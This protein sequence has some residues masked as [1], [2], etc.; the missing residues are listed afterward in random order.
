MTTPNRA[1]FDIAPGET[2]LNG[3]A[4]APMPRAGRRAVDEAYV[5]KASPHRVTV[6]LMFS[7]HDRVRERLG[8][9]LGLAASEWGVTTSTTFGITLLAQGIRW[10]AGDRLLLGPDEFPS[11]VYPWLPLEERGVTLDFIGRKGHPLAPDDLDRALDA[12]GRVRALTV[13]AVHYLTG[14]LHP[15]PAFAER[16]HARGALL[17]VDASQAA[18]AIALDWS[19]TGA[20]AIVTSGYKWLFGPYGCGAIWVRP[21]VRETLVDANGNW[22]AFQYGADL[23]RIMDS[24]PP[25]SRTPLPHGRRFDA[26]EAASFLNVA[27]FGAGLEYLTSIGVAA[28]EAHHRALQD[29]IVAALDGLPLAPRTDLAAPHR[30]PMVMVEARGG[31]DLERLC[32]DLAARHVH[33]S[34][35]SGRMRVSPGAWNDESDVAVF[36]EAV[37]QSVGAIGK[38][39]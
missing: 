39:R 28:V 17:V 35:R 8:T 21:A 38:T 20:D 37:A 5:L 7:Y 11:N 26:G 3:A 10:R 36:A 16:L 4:M 34:L 33:V 1:D 29:R 24:Y 2:Y 22:T 14:N 32:A 23:S 25:P 27:A 15:L 31:I 19:A 18:G 12:D 9:A 30:A 13:A 6:D